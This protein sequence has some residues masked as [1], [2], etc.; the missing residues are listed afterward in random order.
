MIEKTIPKMYIDGILKL[1]RCMQE[2]IAQK[3][4]GIEINPSSNLAIS[5]MK[6]YADH[7]VLNLY[8]LGLG[9]FQTSLE[10]EYALLAASVE[11]L[12]D[13]NGKKL[14]TPQEVYEW[15]N[16]IRVMGNQQVF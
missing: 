13:E 16:H 4:I 3:G 8:S 14:Y 15:L 2:K 12:T 9:V 5:T 11:S 1:Q 6:T 10:N 7:P